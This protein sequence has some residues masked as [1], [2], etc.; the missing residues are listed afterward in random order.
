MVQAS[1]I[2]SSICRFLEGTAKAFEVFLQLQ[3]I[4]AVCTDL[5]NYLSVD[6][7]QERDIQIRV[8]KVSQVTPVNQV[9][10]VNPVTPVKIQVTPPVNQVK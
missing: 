3:G 9:T 10:Q 1:N 8:N 5:K 4:K 6:Y 7:F 2:Q